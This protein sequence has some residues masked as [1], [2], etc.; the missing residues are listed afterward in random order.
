MKSNSYI[1]LIHICSFRCIYIGLIQMFPITAGTCVW[2]QCFLYIN[3]TRVIGMGWIAKAKAKKKK[4]LHKTR[5]TYWF[6][7]KISSTSTSIYRPKQPLFWYIYILLMLSL[8]CFSSFSPY[9]SGWG[10][11]FF[12]FTS[13]KFYSKWTFLKEDQ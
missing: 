12:F 9:S 10:E 1:V 4:K 11:F 13:E 5:Y 2:F 7:L 8:L 6:Y 3:K